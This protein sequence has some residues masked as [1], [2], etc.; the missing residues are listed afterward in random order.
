[1][2]AEEFFAI[3]TALTLEPLLL[4]SSFAGTV[5]IV[6][7]FYPAWKASFGKRLTQFAA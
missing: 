1:V 7:G 2:I 4:A 3:R 6:F 5:G